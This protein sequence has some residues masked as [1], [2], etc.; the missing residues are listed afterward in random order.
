MSKE[1]QL[2]IN[3][4]S[5]RKAYGETQ[6]QLGQVLNVEKNTISSYETGT[7]EPSK[8]TVREI[9][10]HYMISTEELLH[11]DLSLINKIQIDKDAFWKYID[12]VIPI[13]S[14]EK[15]LEN[16]HF[17]KAYDAHKD[18]Y[19]ELRQV[20]LDKIDNVDVCL[21][22]YTE[23]LEDEESGAM[24]AAN[25]IGLEYLLL[26]GIKAS[27]VVM[28]EQPAALMQVARKDKKTRKLIENPNPSLESDAEE[29]MAEF[30][31][32]ESEEIMSQL[33]TTVKRSKEWSDLGDYYLALRYMWNL[34]DN[35]LDWGF[36]Q[37]IGVEMLNSFA[38]VNNIYAA[39]FL[40]YSFDSMT[41]K[42]SRSVDDSK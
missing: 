2:G 30:H 35:D 13:A 5:L 33:L 10:K 8:D 18:F 26:M 29:I 23:V 11:S 39:R 14:S 31:N 34:V 20:S 4:R 7:R 27:A 24:A 15:A 19:D 40:I 9:A 1:N 28:K 32:E 21:E 3:I 37:R 25:I 6:E 22:E 38:S 12:I 42:S 41:G 36:N 17:R 16:P